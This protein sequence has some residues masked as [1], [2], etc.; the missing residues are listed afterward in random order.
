[1]KTFYAFKS[2][3]VPCAPQLAEAT[4]NATASWSAAVLCRFGNGLVQ[5]KAAEAGRPPKPR[6]PLSLTARFVQ[7]LFVAFPVLVSVS[8]FGAG[9]LQPYATIHHGISGDPI[10]IGHAFNNFGASVAGVGP[11]RFVVGVPA[12]EYVREVFPQYWISNDVGRVYLYGTNGAAIRLISH[13]NPRVGDAFGTAVAAIGNTHFVVSAPFWDVYRPPEQN[14]RA[15]NAG[16]VFVFDRLGNLVG[17][18]QD[19]GHQ[20]NFGTSVTGVGTNAF[21]VGSPFKDVGTTNNTGAVYLY[22][23]NGTLLKAITNRTPAAFDTFGAS[24]AGVGSDR[25]VVGAPSD[26]TRANNAGAAY[27]YSANGNFLAEVIPLAAD[28]KAGDFFASSLAGIGTNRFVVGAPNA[29][30]NATT[31]NVGRVFIFG[32]NGNLLHRI[33]NP[34]PDPNTQFGSSLSRVGDDRFLVSALGVENYAGRAYLYTSDGVLLLKIH[35]P[36]PRYQLENFGDAMAGIGQDRFVIGAPFDDFNEQDSG[37]VYVYHAPIAQYRLGFVVDMP[38]G[39]NENLIPP[40]GPEV[41]P[42][43]ATFWHAPSKRLY[44]AKPGKAL[45]RWL[46]GGNPSVNVEAL[47][48]W[49]TNHTDYQTNVVNSLPVDLTGAGAYTHAQLLDQDAGVGTSATEVQTN[50]RFQTT[51]AGRSLLLLSSGSPG[52]NPVFFQLVR[53]VAWNNAAHLHDHAP[54]TVGIEITNTFTYHNTNCGGPL[55]FWPNSFYCP[56]ANFHNRAQRSGP[57]IPVNTDKPGE[58]NDLVLICYQEGARLK[59]GVGAN[60]SSPICW[61][62]KPVRYDAVWPTA[63]TNKIIIASQQGTGA[64]DPLAFKNW[65]IYS[66][67]DSNAPGF[68]PND[69]HALRAPYDVG[70]AIF[71]LRDDLGTPATSEPYVLMKYFDPARMDRGQ[72]KVFRVI[73]E[74]A[75]YFFNYPGDAAELVQPPFPL[76]G[77]LQLCSL[78]A[79]VS[80]P[81]WRDRKGDFW[82]RAADA[83]G[84]PATIVMH[85]HYPV[86]PTFFFPAALYPT[87]LVPP[88][89]ACIPWLDFRAGTPGVPINIDY[90]INWPDAP[91]LRAR[92]TLVKPKNF[93]PDIS[94]QTSVEIIYQQAEELGQGQS[95]KLIDPTREHEVHLAQLPSDVPTVNEGGQIFFPALPPSLRNRLRYDPINQKLKFL[96][97]LVEPPGADYYLL[98]NVITERERLVL[99]ELSSSA[100]FDAAINALATQAANAIEVAPDATDFDS[101]ALTA[102]FA[103]AP[104]YVTLAFGNNPNLSPLAEP[105]VLQVIKVTCPL[106]RGEVKVI[107]SA[108]PFDE[109]LTLRHSG[110]FAGETDEFQFEWRTLPPVDGLPSTQP[111]ELW[112]TFTPVP[113]TGVGAVDITIAG[114]GLQTLSDNYFVCRYQRVLPGGVC[115]GGWSEWTEPQLAEGWIK[116]VLR[117]INPFEQRIQSYRDNQVNTIVSMISQ[118]GTRWEGNAPLNQAA[119]N[120]FGLIE[121]Y[122]TVLQR[123][124][125]LSIDGTPPVNYPPANDALLLAAGRIADLYMLLGN[126]AYADAADPTIAFGTSHGVYGAEAPSIHCFMN[127]MASLLDEELALLRGRDDKL[128]PG[129]R[130]RPFY[131]RLVWNFTSDIDG[132]EVAYALNYN[133]RDV[134]GDVA[135]SINEADARELYPQAHGDAWGHYLTAIKNYYRLLLNPNFTWVPRVEAVLVGGVPVSVDFLDERNFAKAAAARAR[136]GSEIVNLTYRSHYV[137]DPQGQ[138]QGYQDTDMDRAWGLAEWGS[139]AGQGSYLDW[140]VGNAILP[141]VDGNPAHVG[142][143]KVDRTTVGELRDVLSAFQD[144]QAQV[145]NADA[146]LNPLG[147]AKNVIPFDIDPGQVLPPTCKTHFEQIYDRAVEALNNAI[148]VFNYANNSSQRLRQQADEVADFQQTV[149][150]RESDFNSRLIEVFGYPYPED[151]GPTGTYLSGYNGPDLYHYDY[152]D[153][154][155]LTGVVQPPTQPL[156]VTFR[157][158]SVGAAGQLDSSQKTVEFNI[159]E[160]TFGLVK[161]DEWTGQRRAPGEIQLAR[162][163]FLQTFVRFRQALVNYDNLLSSIEDH[164]SLLQTHYGLRNYEL[165][166]LNEAKTNQLD[167]TSEINNLREEQMRF[168]LLGEN[169]YRLASAIAEYMPKLVG[170]AND[171]TSV[172]RGVT[173]TIGTGLAMEFD[174]Q[175]FVA[176]VDENRALRRKEELEMLTNIRL[177]TVRTDFAILQSV[178]QVEQLI[179][180]Q[181]S[182]SLEIF[183]LRETLQ[184]AAGRYLAALS[185]GQRLLED[186]LRFRQQ[187]AAQVQEYRYKDMAFRIF[188]ND[189]LQKYRAQFDLAAR[190]VFLA[191]RTYDFETNLRPGD[192]G[193]PGE[194]FMTQIVRA[195]AIGLIQDRRPQVG[196]GNGDA[197]LADPMARMINNWNLVLKSKL[198]FCNPQTETGRFSLRSELFRIQA[199]NQGRNA[200]RETLARHVIPNVLELPEFQRYCIP[201]TPQQPVEPAIVIP[202][203]TTINFGFNFFGW[204]AGGGDNEYDS[205]HFTTKIRS[206]GVWFANYNS[207]GGGMIN[208]PRVYLIPVGNDVMRS[209]TDLSGDIREWK[210]LDQSLPVP[211]PLSGAALSHPN[212]IP[213]NDSLIGLFG[214]LRRYA[215]F[216]AYH[217]SGNFNPAE[218]ISDS[219]LIGRSV[220]N[221]RW[222]LIIPAGTLHGDRQEGLDRFIHGALFNGVRDG[223]GVSDIKIFFQTY[224]Y[225]GN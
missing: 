211:F 26:D 30:L 92:E 203:S 199:G 160:H 112:S 59:N 2:W 148:A 65:D 7:R 11:D 88:L 114:P 171:M 68:N 9:D 143:Q 86:Q 181:A 17:S 153:L 190:Y 117:G 111:P 84:G 156:S 46:Q 60:V 129:V 109:K 126:E 110:D 10:P 74:E 209:P 87:G 179:R 78:N 132:G 168:G 130:N 76:R 48:L 174:L 167:L 27:L 138:Y 105:V 177:T 208:T 63:T 169:A 220:W 161:P 185:R 56:D 61:P 210:I 133:I 192:S 224:A 116:R 142:I 101:L 22:S 198:N 96:G 123:G 18:V 42:P 187:T 70:E 34:E 176:A 157:E 183:A 140:V 97:E 12:A 49:S 215:R 19:G 151:I 14:P 24:V 107:E 122:E 20:D 47:F 29:D 217:D 89:G 197:G 212:W 28:L 15:T 106:Y 155:Q 134:D 45:I 222:L 91:E 135:G 207:L 53:S 164:G 202:F 4:A 205:T 31:Q 121:I 41:I 214:D 150:N 25:F 51:G 182:Q 128:L 93:L 219:R 166:V 66:Q 152:V 191:A 52:A 35:K 79:G 145:D 83:G 201:F 225:S 99:Q 221:T 108:N 95:V 163:D 173:M 170:T 200:W 5:S 62:W 77:R 139:R 158:F 120:Q 127:Q 175:R 165:Q 98:L 40:Q 189:A 50:L 131:N 186:R 6:G 194:E 85:F 195:R 216:R 8:V 3:R 196:T 213:G 149:V 64:I 141:P 154:S 39:L 33:E 184:Q 206:A 72:I 100:T 103:D 54:A 204:P 113:A 218:T 71:A 55:V 144:I 90:T 146:G 36:D 38:S 172:G 115:G 32:E 188:R 57:I 118:A 58:A 69:E 162:S 159:A 125:S 44:A 119:A 193:G 80:G 82:A 137:E 102:G 75:P 16:I 43:D 81:Y 104:G 23:L 147:L 13:P 223:N 73:A 94:S 136:T 67:N 1:M 178:A 124:R 180:E 21:V 37:S